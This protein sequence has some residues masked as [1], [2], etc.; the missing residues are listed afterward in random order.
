MIPATEARSKRTPA[1]RAF[2]GMAG[3]PLAA[4]QSARAQAVP[5]NPV[6]GILVHFCFNQESGESKPN[7]CG[8]VLRITKEQAYELIDAGRAHFLLVKNPKTDKLTKYHRAIVVRQTVVD[9]QTLYAMEKPVKVGSR[10]KKHQY[11]R[12]SILLDARRILQKAFAAGVISQHESKISDVDLEAT[13][14]DSEKM[15]ARLSCHKPLQGKWRLVV[16][17]WYNNI[18]G[19]QH[20]NVEAQKFLKWADESAGIAVTG[21]YD[22]AKLGLVD[23]AHMTDDGRVSVAN[24]RASFWNGSWDYSTGARPKV[25]QDE[26]DAFEEPNNINEDDPE[27]LTELELDTGEHNQTERLRDEHRGSYEGDDSSDD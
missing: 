13:L 26:G 7:R 12:T 16:F 1:K 4:V 3:S 22:S 8:C 19:F 25:D 21:G 20:L 5:Q 27:Q 24:H 18:L 10:E 11:I 2:V 15:L 23:G 9:G 6:K 17:H 14:E